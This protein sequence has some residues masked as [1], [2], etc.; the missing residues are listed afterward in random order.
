MERFYFDTEGRG[1]D[2]P[3]V[4]TLNWVLDIRTE[5]LLLSWMIDDDPLVKLWVPDLSKVLHPEVWAFV[6]RRTHYHGELP[7]E[8]KM[9][10][11]NPN[12]AWVAWNAAFDRAVIDQVGYL[13]GFPKMGI[14]RFLDA[15][16]QAM[17]SNLPGG[18]DMAGR[19]LRLGEKTIGGKAIMKRFADPDM[20]LPGAQELFDACTTV[21]E[22]DEL[23]R[24][25]LE[26]WDLYLVY[27][28]QDTK[29]MK[30]IWDVTRPLDDI[31]WAEYW[32][33]EEI[34]DHGMA[35]DIEFATAAVQYKDEEEAWVIKRCIELTDGAVQGPTF[36]AKI[37]AWVYAHLP[38]SLQLSMVKTWKEIDDEGDKQK[39]PDKLTCDKNTIKRLLEDIQEMDFQLDGAVEDNV[40]EFL[41][42]LEYGRSTSATKFQ[43]IINQAVPS[44]N[45]E[46][47]PRLT[48]SYVFN[49]AGQ[50]GR[51]SSR[52]VQI[53]NL[54]NKPM[55][56]ELDVM[57]MI[58][59]GVPIEELR[60]LP[61]DKQM[62]E[63]WA[64][65]NQ[66]PTP[67][68]VS[69]ILG[70][71]IRPTFI[72]PKKRRYVWCDWS[73]IEA[74]ITPWLANTRDAR[75]KVLEP[76]E[77]GED[78]YCANAETIFGV[79]AAEI[80]RLYNEGDVQAFGWRQ[81]GKISVLSLGFLGGA[82][83]Y[84]AM[85][86]SYGVR[87]TNE[88]AQLVVDGWRERNPW[89]RAFG[90]KAEAAAF[91]A[92]ANPLRMFDAGRL[93][94]CFYPELMA[95]TLVCHLPCGRMLMYPMAQVSEIE[96]F[97]KPATAI[98][99]LNGNGRVST[100]SGKLI[101]N[102]TQAYAAS[103]LRATLLRIKTE[104]ADWRATGAAFVCGDT[105]DE[106]I[107]ECDEDL[108]EQ[109]AGTYNAK[110]E[111]E[112][113]MLHEIMVRGF[114]HSE[115]LPLAAAAEEDWYYHK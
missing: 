107:V 106:I 51:F 19:A 112:G 61:L 9:A 81:A 70:R 65:S 52:G 42:L 102:A 50:T 37:T 82:G 11:T 89:A 28:G 58:I 79:P 99:Y 98:T 87:A 46:D 86:R 109:I 75:E 45:P 78:L 90:N 16:A 35:V 12:C 26:Q 62:V 38:A 72:T 48:Y 93:M 25:S 74:R 73:A 94:Y 59:Q 1:P 30:Q 64:K 5:I 41:E 33:H 83:A 80:K 95:G 63:K 20:P 88:E 66:K 8:V 105:H 17:A 13:Y 23:M 44:E 104:W 18:L 71:L 91:S 96:K 85:A 76:F 31:E 113:G 110:G 3:T 15:Q 4:G 7:L 22:R 47:P 97:G 32:A 77:R 108:V 56:N 43:K 101:E 84:K 60:K 111:L 67:T 69:A 21:E 10:A 6:K 49:G 40:V 27:G 114:D 68:S 115:G 36:S 29:L 53:H 92:I 39:V 55:M 103:L 24:I 57:D 34:N 100:W 2:L 14:G 54:P